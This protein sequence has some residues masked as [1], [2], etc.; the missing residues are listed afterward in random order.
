MIS[1]AHSTTQRDPIIFADEFVECSRIVKLALDIMYTLEVDH[2]EEEDARTY[3]YVVDFA[4]KWDIDLISNAI[5]KAIR[6]SLEAITNGSMEMMLLAWKLNDNGLASLAFAVNTDD[7]LA[8][9][10]DSSSKI[11]CD[12][13]GKAEDRDGQ[14]R[15]LPL[16]YQSEDFPPFAGGQQS[17]GGVTFDLGACYHQYFLQIPPTIVWIILKSQHL[18]AHD[19]TPVEAH[20]KRL[21]DNACKHP[22]RC[23]R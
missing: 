22:A 17:Y 21:M 3:M 15:E 7:W 4:K 8:Y 16:N 9:S 12:P 23:G 14:E 20:F 18:A 6:A 2:I 11:R 1:I 19:K 13:T 5:G 10:G